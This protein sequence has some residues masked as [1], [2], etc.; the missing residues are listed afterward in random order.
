MSSLT[1]NI[2]AEKTLY[3]GYGC[4]NEGGCIA[5]STSCDSNISVCGVK[6][7]GSS[8]PSDIPESAG[9]HTVDCP[10]REEETWS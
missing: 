10:S 7:I 3:G 2:F 8:A 1:L 6:S 5:V 4:T 9:E